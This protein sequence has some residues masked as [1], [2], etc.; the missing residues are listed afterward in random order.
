MIEILISLTWKISP[1]IHHN[2]H[3]QS[4]MGSHCQ[5]CPTRTRQRNFGE[6][7]DTNRKCRGS[8]LGH[9][10]WVGPSFVARREKH[11][12]LFGIATILELRILLLAQ[13]SNKHGCGLSNGPFN[14]PFPNISE[15]LTS[16]CHQPPKGGIRPRHGA[17]SLAKAHPG[18]QQPREHENLAPCLINLVQVILKTWCFISPWPFPNREQMVQLRFGGKALDFIFQL[19]VIETRLTTPML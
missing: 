4:P 3:T 18:S 10:C 7:S 16:Q 1:L 2:R 5:S 13:G 14:L 17:T 8:D 12:Y 11:S 15:R 6:K 19:F 9:N